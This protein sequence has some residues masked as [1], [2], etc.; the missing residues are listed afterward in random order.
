MSAGTQKDAEQQVTNGLVEWADLIFAMEVVHRRKIER[1]HRS[2]L[3]TTQIVVLGI[4]DKFRFMDP[5]L[6]R[7][8]R[9][10]LRPWFSH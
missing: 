9:T 6:V 5:E 3:K 10:R 2:A 7:V 1:D 8:L 4:L